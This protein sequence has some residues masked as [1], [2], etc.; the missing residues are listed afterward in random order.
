MH[1]THTSNNN[2]N[3]YFST[4]VGSIATLTQ[5]LTFR[6][7]GAERVATMIDSCLKKYH[8][9]INEDFMPFALQHLRDQVPR[10]LKV[11][12]GGPVRVFG[13]III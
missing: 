10:V 5:T 7:I 8:Y 3:K 11:R 2:N 6:Q 9:S 12:R 1:Q 13:P 4:P